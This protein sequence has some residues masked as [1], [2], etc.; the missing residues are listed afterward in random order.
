MGIGIADQVI[1]KKAVLFEGII[2]KN[3]MGNTVVIIQ[4][5]APKLTAEP[6]VIESL[7]TLITI[8]CSF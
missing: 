3:S 2:E 5:N 7:H 1:N 4:I 6:R 8:I